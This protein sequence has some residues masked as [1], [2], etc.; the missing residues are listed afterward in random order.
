[1]GVKYIISRFGEGDGGGGSEIGQGRKDRSRY[2]KA[3]IKSWF[4]R[5]IRFNEGTKHILSFP[6]TASFGIIVYAPYHAMNT[7]CKF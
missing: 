3:L 2:D 6:F 7:K 1:M 5:Y 4:M